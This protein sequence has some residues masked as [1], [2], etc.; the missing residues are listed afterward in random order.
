MRSAKR[1]TRVALFT[2]IALILNL[3]ESTLPPLLPFAPGAKMG[4][5]NLVTLVALMI[6]GYGDAYLILALKCL[7]GSVFGGNI[8]ALIYSVPAG[9]ASLTVQVL[10]YHFLY[11]R[12]SIMSVSFIGA[13]VFNAVQVGVASLV[14]GANLAAILP[15]MLI[16][17]LIAGLA[18]G[19]AAF[20]TVKYLPK[21][22]YYS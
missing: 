9:F 18:V 22:I 2:A 1:I 4:L 16:A 12:L 20:L 6:L 13:F 11:K 19:I 5:S 8:T 10:A 14:T 17:S 7:L 3:V 21:K 15:F